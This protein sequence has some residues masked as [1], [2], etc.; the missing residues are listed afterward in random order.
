MCPARFSLS[1]G[2][3]APNVR[4]RLVT[5]ITRGHNGL[6]RGGYLMK[7]KTLGVVSSLA[8]MASMAAPAYA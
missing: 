6:V 8:I 4:C 5:N 7:F 3:L 2:F 1:I